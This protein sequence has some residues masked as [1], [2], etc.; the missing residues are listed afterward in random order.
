[1]GGFES[2]EFRREEEEI[3]PEIRRQQKERRISF[4]LERDL[5]PHQIVIGGKPIRLEP[6]EYR[7]LLF[8]AKRPYHAFSTKEILQ[9]VNVDV[10]VDEVPVSE[11][12]LRLLVRSLR[13]KLGFFWDYVQ[14]VPY[15]GYRFR[16]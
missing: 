2:H 6:R 11:Q 10:E 7:F 15:I 1:M 14:V 3:Q 16:P 5:L 9:A 12:S 8:L 13:D 4:D